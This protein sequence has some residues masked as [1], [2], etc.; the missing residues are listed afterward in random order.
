MQAGAE[1]LY[2]V[3]NHRVMW[4]IALAL[5]A[6]RLLLVIFAFRLNGHDSDRYIREAVNLIRHGTFSGDE[7]GGPCCSPVFPS[8]ISPPYM[9]R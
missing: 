2:R 9:G 5:F 4:Y 1:P 6:S 7:S 3:T 8:S